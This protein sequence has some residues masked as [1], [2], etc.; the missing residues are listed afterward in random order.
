MKVS[1]TNLVLAA[2]R[3]IKFASVGVLLFLF[4]LQLV[5]A[6]ADLAA[7]QRARLEGTSTQGPH[8]DYV[9]FYA[10]GKMVGSGDGHKLY[11]VAEVAKV[12]TS[13]MGRPVGGRG[14]LAYFNP[15]FVALSFLLPSYLSVEVFSL[16][17]LLFVAGMVV[18]AGVLLS[19]F[20]GLSKSQLLVAG[21]G[22]FSLK[23]VFWLLL[24]GQLSMFIFIGW[25][26]FAMLYI[27]GEKGWA[28][29]TLALALVKPQV[30][31]LLLAM[32][33]WK[34]D[35]Q[36][37]RGFLPVAAGLAGISLLV[38][39]PAVIIDY[40][41]FLMDSTGFDGKGVSTMGMYGINGFIAK[42][43]G[44]PTPSNLWLLALG[45]IVL[46]MV[47]D[48]WRKTELSAANLPLLAAL[49]LSAGLLLNPHL[50]FQDIVLLPLALA[51]GAR[52]A[53]DRRGKFGY[54]MPLAVTAWIV[55]EVTG[56]SAAIDF[57]LLTPLMAGLLIVSYVEL[58][59]AS[60]RVAE[61]RAASYDGFEISP[62]LNAA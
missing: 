42:L 62:P 37:L 44:D 36:T 45:P 15:P 18:L 54:W 10:A 38:S 52:Y 41:E 8:E 59:R 12:E 33:F 47:L 35:W 22:F 53:Y 51:F 2:K 55:Q 6:A 27:R 13:V 4:S 25:L 26:G 11:D 1:R 57:N 16:A 43:T 56:P 58:A 34:R 31:L 39:G 40:P 32:L 19:R 23:C 5:D 50:Y 46:A 7:F 30:S 14:E 21:L 20:L 9:V 3:V 60:A 24:H 49:T 28:G 29:A 48:G 61:P 17:L